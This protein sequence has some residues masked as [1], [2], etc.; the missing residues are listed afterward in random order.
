LV[1]NQI[2]GTLYRF[3]K[4]ESRLEKEG[5]PS[6]RGFDFEDK[7]S[8]R[9]HELVSGFGVIVRPPRSELE[10]PSFSGIR[11]P[12]DNMFFHEK[13]IYPIE[14]K[15]TTHQIEHLYAFNGKILD[16]AIG[17]KTNHIERQ[18]RGIFLSTMPLGRSA[19]AFAFAYGIIPIDPEL[20]PVEHM[21]ESVR[22]DDSLKDEL[23]KLSTKTTAYMPNIL[24]A[25]ERRDGVKLEEMF[26][27]LY[28]DW[29]S[30]GYV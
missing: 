22:D 29:K 4:E 23:R 15:A 20:P 19:R 7:V 12:F 5:T 24:E 6:K 1:L 8:R 2:V 30:K 25:H 17:L 28:R 13:I 11:H 27:H 14:C 21:I 10:Y 16:H 3:A 18:I 26:S 9:I